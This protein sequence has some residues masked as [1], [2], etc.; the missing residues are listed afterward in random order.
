M[1]S[2]LNLLNHPAESPQPRGHHH[3]NVSLMKIAIA[4]TI[5]ALLSLCQAD[6]PP[7]E[8]EAS[9]A[10]AS[11]TGQQLLVQ[12]L[13]KSPEGSILHWKVLDAE[14]G[15]EIWNGLPKL[16]ELNVLFPEKSGV[17]LAPDGEHICVINIYLFFNPSGDQKLADQNVV[18]IYNRAS[19]VRK[20]TLGEIGVDLPKLK[21]SSSHVFPFSFSFRHEPKNLTIDNERITLFGG[22]RDEVY[23]TFRDGRKVTWSF[24]TG[25]ILRS[26]N[27]F[28]KPIIDD[29]KLFWYLRQLDGD[30]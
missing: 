16:S 4:A 6:T 1:A 27:I 9:F 2:R 30:G 22:T 14:S 29:P 18:W 21:Q 28:P 13:E 12:W 15:K 17:F 10:V 8:D 3:K 23:V 24:Q 11:N 26:K 20:F 19:L 7:S 5:T 25:E